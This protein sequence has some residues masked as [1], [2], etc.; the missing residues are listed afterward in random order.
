MNE[1]Y[2]QMIIEIPDWH[3][4]LLAETW[5]PV[6]LAAPQKESE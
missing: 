3:K 5:L 6:L 1:E 4:K 2:D